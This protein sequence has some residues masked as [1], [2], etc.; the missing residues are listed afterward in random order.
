MPRDSILH[1]SSTTP[2]AAAGLF[3]S[4]WQQ[5]RLYPLAEG[6]TSIPIVWDR[7][8]IRGSVITDQ[9]SAANGFQVQFANEDDQSDSFPAY[10]AALAANIPTVFDVQLSA[11][12]VRIELTNGAT[13]QTL[14]ELFARL[15]D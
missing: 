15:E 12:Y 2:L 3:T 1:V 8:R 5:V 13:P 4:S 10:Q 11:K 14:L 7:N 9:A 6:A